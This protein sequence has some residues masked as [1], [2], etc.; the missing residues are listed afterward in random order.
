MNNKLLLCLFLLL[1][2]QVFS[3]ELAETKVSTP[4]PFTNTWEFICENY[5]LT[6]ITKV[7]ITKTDKGGM[8]KLSV[9]TTNPSYTIAGTV[10][11]DLADNTVITC[12]DKKI[13]EVK[14]N[15]ITAC[16]YFS[17]IEMN[18]LKITDIQTIR[19]NIEGNQKGFSSQTG[20]F[21]A[22][23]KKKYFSTVFDK[24]KKSYD[25]AT[26]ISGLYN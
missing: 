3:Q 12:L 5:A 24:S 8:L 11:V 15:E 16:Y 22:V 23:N 14:G 1:S 4:V 26:E 9:E 25:T 2:I 20:N 7:Q 21:T 19:F 13:R 17:N 6:G 18:K 10:Y